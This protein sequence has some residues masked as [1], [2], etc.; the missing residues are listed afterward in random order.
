M[1]NPQRPQSIYNPLICSS[2]N[3]SIL[4][5]SIIYQQSKSTYAIYHNLFKRN[6]IVI[7]DFIVENSSIMVLDVGYM[8][9]YE[10]HGGVWVWR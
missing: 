5:L 6:D 3:F 4:F 8:V 7:N 10:A 9:V 2:S 1:Q